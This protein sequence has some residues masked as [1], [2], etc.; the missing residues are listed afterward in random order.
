[1]FEALS[2]EGQGR[3]VIH[4]ALEIM[5]ARFYRFLLIFAKSEL[6]ALVSLCVRV[7]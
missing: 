3:S 2:S 4:Q 7:G 5:P 1:M 6:P